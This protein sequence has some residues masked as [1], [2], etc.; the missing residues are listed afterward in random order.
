MRAGAGRDRWQSPGL[1]SGAFHE[2]SRSSHL[3]G[4]AHH[5]IKPGLDRINRLLD[6]MGRPNEGYPIIHVQEPTG[7][8][9][10]HGSQPCSSSPTG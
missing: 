10:P 7:R 3:P 9:P 2:L 6:D 5:G 1:T 8:P 4:W